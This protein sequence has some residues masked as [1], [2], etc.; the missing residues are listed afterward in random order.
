MRNTYNTFVGK[1]EEDLG[2]DGKIIQERI[3]C[4]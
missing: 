4:K 2:V 1:C 3:V